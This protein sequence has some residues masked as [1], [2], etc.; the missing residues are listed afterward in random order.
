MQTP[1][2]SLVKHKNVYLLLLS[3]S[4]VTWASQQE[5]D[6][7]L[8]ALLWLKSNRA[9]S[10]RQPDSLWAVGLMQLHLITQPAP[11]PPF[12]PLSFLFSGP[13]VPTCLGWMVKTVRAQG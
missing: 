12:P 6:Q 10:P 8:Q 11:L 5:T 9:S 2:L 1:L 4:M 13:Q 7:A 3:S